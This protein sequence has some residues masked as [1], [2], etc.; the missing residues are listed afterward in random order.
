MSFARRIIL[1]HLRTGVAEPGARRFHLAPDLLINVV[2]PAVLLLVAAEAFSAKVE[3][4]VSGARSGQQQSSTC[5]CER[6]RSLLV[7]AAEIFCGTASARGRRQARCTKLRP[8][9]TAGSTSCLS[10]ADDSVEF[11]GHPLQ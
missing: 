11:R 5:K 9:P 3:I 7:E 1:A 10:C 8:L 2:L 4:E 6:Q